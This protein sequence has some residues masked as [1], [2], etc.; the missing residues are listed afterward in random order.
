M[1]KFPQFFCKLTFH[2]LY[3]S[4]KNCIVR[5]LLHYHYYISRVVGYCVSETVCYAFIVATK[6]TVLK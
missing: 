4:S 1:E 6:A 5:L 3:N 2:I